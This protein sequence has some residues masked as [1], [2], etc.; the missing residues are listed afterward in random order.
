MSYLYEVS[1]RCWAEA[2]E[3]S[4]RPFLCNYSTP[5]RN[6]RHPRHVWIDLDA[7]LD[8]VYG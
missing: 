1:V 5:S 6:K 7:R 4:G 3:Q 8:D 2:C